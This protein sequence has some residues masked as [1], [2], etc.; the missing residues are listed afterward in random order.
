MN[1][2]PFMASLLFNRNSA[3]YVASRVG[4]QTATMDEDDLLGQAILGLVETFAYY[5]IRGSVLDLIRKMDL[6]LQSA[7]EDRVKLE[8]TYERLA[9]ELG[10][11]PTD[12]EVAAAMGVALEHVEKVLQNVHAQTVLSLDLTRSDADTGPVTVGDMLADSAGSPEDVVIEAEDRTRLARAIEELPERDRI[13]ISLYYHERLT[14]KEISLILEVSEAR[15]C[16]LHA[17]AITKLRAA[18]AA[19]E[20]IPCP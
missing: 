20:R 2:I 16:Q 14:M 10:R 3:R 17:R 7:N 4:I 12:E 11:Q 13:V 5:R 15:V 6:L 8:S 19:E 1:H 9:S 18:L